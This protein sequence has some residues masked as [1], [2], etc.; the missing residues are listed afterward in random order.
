MTCSPTPAAVAH[1][2]QQPLAVMWPQERNRGSKVGGLRCQRHGS[3]T[4][5]ASRARRRRR[6]WGGE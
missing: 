3:S 5:R 4:L 1:R 6:R 2:P